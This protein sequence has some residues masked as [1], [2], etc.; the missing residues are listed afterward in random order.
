MLRSSLGILVVCVLVVACASSAHANPIVLSFSGLQDLQQV[1]NFYNGGAGTNYG[2]SFS[3]DVYALISVY[4][5]GAG[6][7]SLGPGQTPAIFFMGNNG[8]T[9]TGTMNVGA[10]FSTG[11][12]FFYTAAFQETVTIWSGANGTGTI[13]ATLTLSPNNGSCSGFPNYCNWSGVSL[14]FTGNAKSVT[15]TGPANGI[16]ITQMNIGTTSLTTPEP[17]SMV[18][19]GT[20]LLG[21]GGSRKIYNK[22][23]RSRWKA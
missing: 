17:S 11:I 19:L 1:G 15:F 20:G 4:K 14:G 12:S 21:L 22:L 8:Q 3:S 16:G 2:I 18:L 5:G 10:G 7:F 9:I 6:G 13:L 23:V